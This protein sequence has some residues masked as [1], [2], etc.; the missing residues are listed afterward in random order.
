MERNI[1]LINACVREQSRTLRLAKR[2]IGSLNGSVTEIDLEREA[3]RP[4]TGETLAGREAILQSGDLDGREAIL[5]SGDLDAPMLRY[6]HAFAAADEI[7]VAAPYW[8]LNFPAAVKTFFEHVTVTGV[9]F[10]YGADGRPI[11][12]CRAKRL[13]YVMTAGGPLLPPNHGFAYVR[14]LAGLFYGIPETVLF[15]AEMLA[16]VGEDVERRIR[17][18]EE[19]IDAFFGKP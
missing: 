2:V 11:G 12:H 1:M 19:Q 7:V 15:S 9:T 4:L 10:S 14:D 13:F 8:D 16:V 18:A 5:Q 6:A 17:A 3:L